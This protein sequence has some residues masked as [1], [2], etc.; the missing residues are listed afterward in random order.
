VNGGGLLLAWVTVQIGQLLPQPGPEPL[1]R[2]QIG[3]VRGQEV[4]LDSQLCRLGTDQSGVVLGFID[5]R[6]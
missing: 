3:T 5:S 6:R 2:H 4:Q 1:D